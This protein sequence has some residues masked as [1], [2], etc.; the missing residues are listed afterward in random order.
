MLLTKE[1]IVIHSRSSNTHQ[2]LHQNPSCCWRSLYALLVGF[3]PLGF[4]AHFRM[5]VY[6]ASAGATNPPNTSIQHPSHKWLRILYIYTYHFI[7]IYNNNNSNNNNK[8]IYIYTYTILYT[9]MHKSLRTLPAT[10]A[11]QSRVLALCACDQQYPDGAKQEHES[12][13]RTANPSARH[14]MLERIRHIYIS[15]HVVYIWI[16]IYTW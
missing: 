8:Y 13:I 3:E 14:S 7:Y 10:P 15:V 6:L 16:Y 9:P 4:P 5:T 1:R 11:P 2:R 12:E